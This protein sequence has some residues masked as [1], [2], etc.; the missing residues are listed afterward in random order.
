M[1]I[2]K[3]INIV[4]DLDG[5]KIALINDIRFQSRRSIDWDTIEEC[6]KEYVGEYFEIIETS[7]RVYIG[8]DFP[9][10][11]SHSKDKKSL[12]GSKCESKSQY[13]ICN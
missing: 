10:E 4:T 3:S 12:K 2:N 9:D 6:L 11:F 13:N 5:R 1:H 7:E 8:T